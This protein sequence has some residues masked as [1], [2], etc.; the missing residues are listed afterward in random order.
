[1]TLSQVVRSQGPAHAHHPMTC[2]PPPT[3]VLRASL[4]TLCLLKSVYW[5]PLEQYAIPKR[6]DCKRLAESS[7]VVES[8]AFL[9]AFIFFIG[10]KL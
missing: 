4:T 10:T 6:A 9:I 3:R 7:Y 1:M 8:I 5:N 2:A